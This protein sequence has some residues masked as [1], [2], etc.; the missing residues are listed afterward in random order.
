M[1]RGETE[2]NVDTCRRRAGQHTEGRGRC[3]HPSLWPRRQ[4]PGQE[5]G[6]RQRPRQEERSQPQPGPEEEES[7]QRA[8]REEGSLQV[9]GQE[10]EEPQSGQEEEQKVSQSL[11]GQGEEERAQQRQGREILISPTNQPILIFS[12]QPAP[13]TIIHHTVLFI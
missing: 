6:E 13:T 7:E 3:Q 5:P 10:E 1:G 2:A 4:R 8:G 11:P 9:P 12:T